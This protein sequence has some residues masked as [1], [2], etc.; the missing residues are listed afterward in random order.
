MQRTVHEAL[1]GPQN[2]NVR[3]AADF[4][5]QSVLLNVEKQLLETLQT[6]KKAGKSM[7]KQSKA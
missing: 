5:K 6:E 2:E 7:S 4:F 1:G 3:Y